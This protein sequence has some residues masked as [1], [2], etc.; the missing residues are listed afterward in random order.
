MKVLLEVRKSTVTVAKKST[1]T[2]FYT[3][4]CNLHFVQAQK[5]LLALGPKAEFLCVKQGRKFNSPTLYSMLAS[6]EKMSLVSCSATS[7]LLEKYG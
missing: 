6:T 3:S 2:L 1:D 5:M 4:E 7:M